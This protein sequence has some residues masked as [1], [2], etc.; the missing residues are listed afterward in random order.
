MLFL[1]RFPRPKSPPPHSVDHPPSFS[2]LFPP[3]LIWERGEEA[4][5]PVAASPSRAKPDPA[6]TEKPGG[7]NR[8]EE[9]KVFSHSMEGGG[10]AK[11]YFATTPPPLSPLLVL[12]EEKVGGF[13]QPPFFSPPPHFTSTQLFSPFPLLL[14]Q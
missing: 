11:K 14:C 7:G 10:Q 2:P 3:S 9:T 13:P 6:A 8:R 5:F 12:R 4:K 1:F